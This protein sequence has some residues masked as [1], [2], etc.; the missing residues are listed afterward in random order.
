MKKKE[1]WG[2][3]GEGCEKRGGIKGFW[4]TAFPSLRRAVRLLSCRVQPQQ[5]PLIP[6]F[7]F[8]L[9]FSVFWTRTTHPRCP[10]LAAWRRCSSAETRAR[11]WR[12]SQRCTCTRV[13]GVTRPKARLQRLILSPCR[14]RFK[15]F[16]T[17]DVKVC[18]TSGEK[19]ENGMFPQGREAWHNQKK[20]IK[21]PQ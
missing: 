16:F 9:N 12:A 6:S 2:E 13:V 19:R 10:L 21:R 11:V 20:N 18:F 8:S 5:Q 7:S 3:N 15:V 4:C 17:A 1:G 14:R